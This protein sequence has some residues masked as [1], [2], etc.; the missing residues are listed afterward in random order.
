MPS[1]RNGFQ[2]F[3]F[4]SSTFGRIDVLRG[5]L[6]AQRTVDFYP[7]RTCILPKQWVESHS[8]WSPKNGL[9]VTWKELELG[10]QAVTSQG[11]KKEERSLEED[12][13]C[14]KK[15]ILWTIMNIFSGRV[16]ASL[17]LIISVRSDAL[18]LLTL[19]PISTGADTGLFPW[20]GCCYF[21]TPK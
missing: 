5:Y 13:L 7:I 16:M 12:L 18:C 9:A 3:S 17:S 19:L 21:A 1:R 2:G 20:G 8:I 14:G 10:Y 6:W 15:C 11:E 4:R